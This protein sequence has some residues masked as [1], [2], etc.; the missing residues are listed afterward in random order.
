LTLASLC[1]GNYKT[2]L[3]S[4]GI[5][6]VG[7]VLMLLTVLNPIV[8]GLGG[9]HKAAILTIAVVGLVLQVSKHHM[10]FA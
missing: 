8:H 1:A 10:F 7:C 4:Y 9:V 2:Q 6:S 5:F 3:V